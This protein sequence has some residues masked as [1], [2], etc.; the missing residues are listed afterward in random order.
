LQDLNATWRTAYGAWEEIEPPRNSPKVPPTIDWR[1]FMDDVYLSFVLKWK[2][3][4]FRHSDPLHRPILAHVGGVTVGS[5]REWRYAQQLD[6]FGSSCYPGWAGLNRWDAEYPSPEKPMTEAAQANHEVKDI[7]MHFDQLRSSKPDGQIWTA[8]LQ[9]GPI[10][11]GLNRRRVPNAADIRRWVLSC[12]AAGSRA[13][14]F[15]NHRPEI[16]WEEGYGFSLLDWGP[17]ASERAEEAG[18]LAHAISAN[19]EIFA[20]GEHPQPAV[21][22]VMNEDLFLFAQGSL[23]DVSQHLEY[24]ITGLW[25][26]LWKDGITAGFVDAS[27]FPSDTSRFKALILPFPLTLS[28]QLI[29]AMTSYVRSGGTLISEACPGRFSNYG[30]G[31]DGAM[32]PGVSELFGTK[33][34]GVFLIREPGKGAKWTIWEFGPRDTREYHDLQGSGSF[35][36]HSV[37]P[38]FYLQTLA[39]TSAKPTL[40]YGT[41]VAGCV[42]EHGAGKAYLV[43]TLLGH[44]GPAYDEWRNAQFLSAILSQAG[45]AP[46]LIGKLQRRRRMF[47]TRAA[48]FFFNS[49][50]E[51][52]EET[53]PLEGFKSARDLL[54]E[55]LPVV[56]GGARVKVGPL[57]VRCV[58]LRP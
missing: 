49:T 58:L 53:V 30:I 43:G 28:P 6:I 39:L 45:I 54:G 2:G 20:K 38:A 5:T 7:L 26:S 55:N 1:Y 47:G 29:A 25:K 3:D 22:I 37:F 42:N 40:T 4:A 24:T 31:F 9:G 32:A 16:F 18:R 19:A 17:D 8:E 13:I 23:H 33:H 50:A 35:A 48:W 57:D 46:D 10:T 11:E 27:S 21:G 52:I 41:E 56:A 51:P 44:A 14:C 34:A 15:W 12:L 36:G